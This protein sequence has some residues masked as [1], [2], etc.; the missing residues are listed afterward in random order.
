MPPQPPLTRNGGPMM[1]GWQHRHH[2]G[3][4]ALASVRPHWTMTARPGDRGRQLARKSPLHQQYR[5]CSSSRTYTQYKIS[6]PKCWSQKTISGHVDDSQD[7]C[8]ASARLMS[9]SWNDKRSAARALARRCRC[10]DVAADLKAALRRAK[11]PC[12]AAGGF[13]SGARHGESW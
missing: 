13:C 4:Q 11:L 6:R 3:K 12:R 2:P 7:L 5:F 8:G 9:K 10:R 1:G